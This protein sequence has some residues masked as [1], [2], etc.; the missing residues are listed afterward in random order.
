M[1]RHRWRDHDAWPRED[2][3]RRRLGRLFAAR[4]LAG[5]RA[6]GGVAIAPP[7]IARPAEEVEDGDRH[8]YRDEEQLL[9]GHRGP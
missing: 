2:D 5:R 6:T 4:L 7:L 3:A 8:E 1:L 9:D